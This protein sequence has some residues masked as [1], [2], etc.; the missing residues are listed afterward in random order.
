MRL[1]AC[2]LAIGLMGATVPAVW[3]TGPDDQIFYAVESMA[4]GRYDQA[5]QAL[6]EVVAQDPGNAYAATRLG[7]A[8]AEVGQTEAAR[9]VLEKALTANP[10][11]LSALWML[12]CLDLV[13]GHTE[14]A[15]A[16]F[17][18]MG[19]A[20]PGNARASLGLGLAAAMTGRT[21][22]ATRFLAEAQAD[23]SP[24]P[25]T[26]YCLGLAYWLLGAPVNARLELEAT[27]EHSPRFAPAL[28]LLGLVY[29][30]QGQTGLAKSAW[31]QA[32]AINS[33]NARA[34]FYLSRLAQDEGLAALLDEHRDEARRAYQRALELDHG[35]EAAA[36]AL[37]ELARTAPA[38]AK[39]GP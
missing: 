21:R 7:L 22:E 14:Q 13:A 33:G 24:D 34:R 37:A 20:D 36:R 5:V 28:T 27:L 8:Q 38:G 30:S 18:A 6:L 17:T 29:R 26:R 2:L 39:T 9:A 1:T 10:A 31:E 25:S 12:G 15:E 4:R 3:A 23:D 16:R 35:N 32:L 19:Q 11:N